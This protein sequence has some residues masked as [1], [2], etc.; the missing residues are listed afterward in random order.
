M[1]RGS[2]PVHRLQSLLKLPIGDRLI[3]EA[4]FGHLE[5]GRPFLEA[6]FTDLAEGFGMAARRR[7]RARHAAMTVFDASKKY[8]VRPSDSCGNKLASHNRS[9]TLWRNEWGANQA[10]SSQ[11]AHMCQARRRVRS[12]TALS[13]ELVV[14][15]MGR[16]MV[17]RAAP[18]WHA[19]SWPS[20]CLIS[21]K[22]P[23]S[24]R[25]EFGADAKLDVAALAAL[26]ARAHARCERTM[27]GG[28]FAS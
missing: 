17:Y 10:D 22:C 12:I 7:I 9:S 20:P 3:A 18:S 25:A 2:M 27:S 8:A 16:P 28:N 19:D 1:H 14:R 6:T 26:A 15:G 11:T 23:T 21:R 4:I 5:I 24:H 13:Q